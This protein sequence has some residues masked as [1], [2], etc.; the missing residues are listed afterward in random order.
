M[1]EKLPDRNHDLPDHDLAD[2]NLADKEAL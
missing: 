2:H 1:E